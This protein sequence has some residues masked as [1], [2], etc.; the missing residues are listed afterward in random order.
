MDPRW[1]VFTS[2]G[3]G[4]DAG[5]GGAVVTGVVW[6]APHPMALTAPANA[7]TWIIRN[8]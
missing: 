5:G 1:V 7:A 6:V 4:D 3:P 8:M 2:V